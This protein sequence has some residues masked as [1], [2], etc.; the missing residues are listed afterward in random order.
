MLSVCVRVCAA[1]RGWRCKHT[2]TASPPAADVDGG[3]RT[4]R[5]RAPLVRPQPS[6]RR[7]ASS[8]CCQCV[9]LPLRLLGGEAR[10]HKRRGD[11][12]AAACT[13]AHAAPRALHQS[14]LVHTHVKVRHHTAS[15]R[16]PSGRGARSAR[17]IT[18]FCALLAWQRTASTRRRSRTHENKLRLVLEHCDGAWRVRRG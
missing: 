9:L 11:V 3:K 15:E 7:P 14:K 6:P 5:D 17:A 12:M 1:E 8:V 10:A 16:R 2:H 13:H 4:A 18:F